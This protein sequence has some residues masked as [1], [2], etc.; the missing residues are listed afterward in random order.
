MR[1]KPYFK[2]SIVLFSALLLSACGFHLRGDYSVP[3]EL[4]KMSVTSYDQYSV[5][6]RDVKNQL[7]LSKVDLVSPAEDIPNLY[8]MSESTAT[9]TLSLY[10]NT[11]TAEQQL[12]MTV[13][14]QVTIP[15]LGS[16][17]FTT[18]VT[19]TYLANSLAALAKSVE[20]DMLENEMRKTAAERILTQMSRLKAN[21]R[22]GSMTLADDSEVDN[23]T[24]STA[25][26]N[27]MS[28]STST[29]SD[30]SSQTTSSQGE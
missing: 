16:K 20:V 9:Q 27:S 29:S 18:T 1:L 24:N 23:Q 10:Q 6:T 7:R 25:E 21:I 15:E 2:L 13:S 8:I 4:N 26:Q 14:Y 17:T 12:K 30:A 28:P 3:A 19:R 22:A 5:L 11:Q